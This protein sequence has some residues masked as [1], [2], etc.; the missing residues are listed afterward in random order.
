MT[1]ILKL[2]LVVLLA[3]SA[4]GCFDY[5][6]RLELNADGSG[7]INQ[8]M[9]LYKEGLQ[10]M[11]QM[12]QGFNEDSTGSA[13]DSS[14]FKFIKRADIE[15]RLA[16]SNG[17]LKLLDFKESQTDSTAIYDIKVS[18][19][20]MAELS[21]F[22]SGWS[23]SNMMPGNPE[24]KDITFAKNKSG[25]WDFTRDIGDSASANLG[26][27]D[28][29]MSIEVTDS[30]AQTDSLM[31]PNPFTDM[32]N[33]MREMMAQAFA[34]HSVKLTVKFPGE[35]A[36]SNAAIISGNEATWDLKMV[37]ITK[38]PMKLTAAIRP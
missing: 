34:N 10:G 18:F 8:H 7:I 2:S 35:V 22:S 25:G 38:H 20:D 15:A 16:G 19:T 14:S 17:K 6:E 11:M 12:L 4:A 31:E 1:K 30:T 3:I 32:G 9:V 27:L 23:N 21:K 36:E 37:E 5:A 26:G 29:D 24:V 28:P 33:M 13:S